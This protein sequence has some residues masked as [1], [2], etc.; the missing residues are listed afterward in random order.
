MY[1]AVYAA[2][3]LP[4]RYGSM[5][6]ADEGEARAFIER[7]GF[8][9]INI[10]TP[11]KPLAL[12]CA[13]ESDAAARLAGGAN[14]LVSEGASV[15][16]ADSAGSVDE[17]R[18]GDDA[19]DKPRLHAYNVDGLGCVAYLEREGVAFAGADTVVCG[20]GPTAM[21]I[22][23]AVLGAGANVRLLGRDAQRTQQA[24]ARYLELAGSGEDGSGNEDANE[25][26][27]AAR[28]PKPA[29]T[30]GSYAESRSA[31][32][33]ADII[34]DA[35]SLGMSEGDPAPF[36]TNLISPRQVVFDTVYGHGTTALMAAARDAG[37]KALDGS[38]MLVGQAVAT[39]D[40]VAR[41]AGI[42]LPFPHDRLFPLM[43]DAAG[44]SL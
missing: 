28:G 1:N 19:A 7:G 34:I 3:G 43:A 12:A 37:A 24:L 30:A 44:F 9:S 21:S 11:Y 42:E 15:A 32:E 23:N 27:S 35:T 8:L 20:T 2:C 33:R 6:I 39:L 41:A 29:V 4:W 14:L 22:L 17:P 31:I 18:E 10:T 38:G 16:R 13:S 36:D 26:G 25:A 5:D 40:I